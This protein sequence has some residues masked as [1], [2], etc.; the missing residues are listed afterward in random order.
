M[1][2]TLCAKLLCNLTSL[3]SS[4]ILVSVMACCVDSLFSI[5]LLLDKLEKTTPARDSPPRN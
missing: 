5:F 3:V 1:T 4:S 2:G